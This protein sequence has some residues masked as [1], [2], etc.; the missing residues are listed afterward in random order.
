[1]TSVSLQERLEEATEDLSR[2]QVASDVAEILRVEGVQGERQH[3]CKCPIAVLLMKRLGPGWVMWVS[4]DVIEA[5]P[6]S[7]HSG[8]GVTSPAAVRAFIAEFDGAE[9]P[10]DQAPRGGWDEFAVA[11]P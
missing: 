3:P 8:A 11:S 1:M 10:A 5:Y 9:V 7:M 6:E 4:D 2:C